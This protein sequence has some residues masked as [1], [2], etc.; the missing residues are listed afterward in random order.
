MSQVWVFAG[1][2]DSEI[3]GLMPFLQTHFPQCQFE[4]KSPVSN[5]P[6][7]KPRR[8]PRPQGET[9]L[10]L[11]EVVK[12]RLTIA[13][14]TQEPCQI[15]FIFDDLDY[16]D[17]TTAENEL[18]NAVENIL[19]Q[20]SA[21]QIQLVI[22]FGKPEIEAWI[23]ANWQNTVGRDIEFRAIAGQM[24]HWLI[25]TKY[26]PADEPENFGLDFELPSY[27]I[28]L[29]EAIIEAAEQ[30]AMQENQPRYSKAIHT[31]RFIQQINPEQVKAKCPVFRAF[32]EQLQTLCRPRP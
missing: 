21:S 6:G 25:T 13:L 4:R 32:F 31:P 3:F 24:Y 16:R 17:K 2:G 5:K 15:I 11:I 1:G 29:S 22:A 28:K 9:G 19:N 26:V 30:C 27:H 14:T 12:K 10:S 7:P 8:E 18:K 20:H 23:I